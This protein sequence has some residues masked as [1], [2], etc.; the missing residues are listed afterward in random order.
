M[1]LHA[2]EWIVF[3]ISQS[4]QPD[5][6][7]A[8]V[9]CFVLFVCLVLFWCE[10]MAVLGSVGVAVSALAFLLAVVAPVATVQGA[11]FVQANK[12][13]RVNQQSKPIE[14]GKRRRS[15]SQRVTIKN[16]CTSSCTARL[17][18]EH[19]PFSLTGGQLR[20][21]LKNGQVRDADGWLNGD[22][23]VYVRFYLGG[24]STEQ[25]VTSTLKEEDN[26]PTWNE[27]LT[28]SGNDIPAKVSLCV[29]VCVRVLVHLRLCVLV[30]VAGLVCTHLTSV[31]PAVVFLAVFVVRRSIRQ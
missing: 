26:T 6:N 28:F 17:R 15:Q 30:F 23:D 19:D 20:I 18:C 31:S 4:D 5:S 16:G 13:C 3:S 8:L 10:V 24:S 2:L 22:S 9:V 14:G 12:L 27:W 29:C 21:Y 1:T 11:S 7:S 25:V